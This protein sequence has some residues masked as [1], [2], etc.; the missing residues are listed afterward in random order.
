[1]TADVLRKIGMNVDLQ[2][3]D[4]GTVV[5][6]RASREPVEKGGWSIFHTTGSAEAYSSPAVNY[7]VRG[8]GE[9]GWFGWWNNPPPKAHGRGM[10]RRL[11]P[12]PTN[13]HRPRHEPPRNGRASCAPVGDTS[14]PP[15]AKTS[16]AC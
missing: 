13:P 16:P 14:K 12:R 6:R 2:E 3:S 10:A 8:P 1:V 5:Q 4:W 9:K 11:R 7:L 15:S